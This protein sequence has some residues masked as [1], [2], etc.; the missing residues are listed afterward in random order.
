M[1]FCRPFF[2]SH[3]RYLL[4]LGHIQT[5]SLAQEGIKTHFPLF[6]NKCSHV[7]TELSLNEWAIDVSNSSKRETVMKIE[8]ETQT[9]D[10]RSDYEFFSYSF[11]WFYLI[12]WQRILCFVACGGLFELVFSVSWITKFHQWRVSTTV[13]FFFL[14]SILVI[15]Q[16]VLLSTFLGVCGRFRFRRSS[17]ANFALI[18]RIIALSSFQKLW[19][20]FAII[21]CTWLRFSSFSFSWG[22]YFAAS[23]WFRLRHFPWISHEI[24]N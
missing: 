8:S 24:K 12:L 7:L 21:L 19:F 10:N 13:F 14:L 4:S 16:F 22:K 20:P 2:F 15:L 3:C 23:S 9:G 17:R 1:R 5:R 6:S 18:S 11:Q